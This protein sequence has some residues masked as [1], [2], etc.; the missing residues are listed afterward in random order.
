[1][2]M[3]L[4]PERRSSLLSDPALLAALARFIRARVP[5]SEVDDIVQS[6]IADALASAHS[7]TEEPEV[8]PW[9]FGIA[10]NKIVDFFRKSRRE[11]PREALEADEVPAESE[12]TS[13]QDLLR[14]A[15]R[16]VPPDARGT[17]DWMIREAHGEKLETIAQEE[18]IPAPRVRQ[19]VTRLRKHLRARWAA[20][21]AAVAA[22]VAV[23]A[24]VYLLLRK[25]NDIALPDPLPTPSGAPMLPPSAPAID[26][27]PAPSSAPLPPAS[28]DAPDAAPPPEPSSKPMPKAKPVPPPVFSSGPTKDDSSFDSKPLPKKAPKGAAP[29]GFD[30]SK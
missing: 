30:S 23:A 20:Q 2:V 24:A 19:R 21:L 17:L 18:Q 8:R 6:T 27:P 28:V 3:P 10:R 1:M 13:A 16:E 26:T 29:Q 14:W 4:A 15:E 9:V 22:I 11:A 12:P 25:K 5:E 7:P